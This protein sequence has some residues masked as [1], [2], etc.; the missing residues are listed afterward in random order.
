M[1]TSVV[2]SLASVETVVAVT[3]WDLSLVNA[4]MATR[5]PT[6]DKTVGTLTSAQR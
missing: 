1:L 3:P 6:T 4:L 2:Y 5:S